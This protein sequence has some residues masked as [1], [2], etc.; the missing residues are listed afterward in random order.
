MEEARQFIE[1]GDYTNAEDVLEDIEPKL[2]DARAII[3]EFTESED[4]EVGE[5]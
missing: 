5:G 1:D 3:D 2:D 4:D